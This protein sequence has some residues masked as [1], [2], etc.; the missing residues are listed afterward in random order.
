ML[1]NGVSV[2]VTTIEVPDTVRGYWNTQGISL[3]SVM[4]MSVDWHEELQRM[5]EGIK[6]RDEK[7][8]RLYSEN[9]RL[10]DENRELRGFKARVLDEWRVKKVKGHE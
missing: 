5:R 7:L 6:V 2:K 8:A 4:R 1:R 10:L 3:A 9:D